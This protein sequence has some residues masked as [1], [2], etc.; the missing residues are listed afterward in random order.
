[1]PISYNH[2]NINTSTIFPPSHFLFN[3]YPG[4]AQYDVF[5]HLYAAPVRGRPHHAAADGPG[6]SIAASCSGGGGCGWVPAFRAVVAFGSRPQIGRL[7]YRFGSKYLWRGGWCTGVLRLSFGVTE[8][9]L[10]GAVRIRCAS[11]NS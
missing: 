3:Y 8:R 2:V 9:L 11:I 10:T 4:S 1:M 7:S 5:F 6:E